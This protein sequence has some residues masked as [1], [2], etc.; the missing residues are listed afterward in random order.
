MRKNLAIV[1][2]FVS[3]SAWAQDE[4]AQLEL[5]L[6]SMIVDV[7]GLQQG[8]SISVKDISFTEFIRAIAISNDINI[9]V[10][11]EIDFRV[12]NNFVDIRVIDV[13]LFFYDNY[14][15]EISISSQIIYINPKVVL[16]SVTGIDDLKIIYS[17]STNELSVDLRMDS[18]HLVCRKISS[19]SD[20]NLVF[21]LGLGNTLITA[22][23]TEL[24]FKE[25]MEQLAFSSGLLI[26]KVDE[27]VYAVESGQ[28]KNESS[29]NKKYYSS[30]LE[31]DIT[32]VGH[33]SIS[34]SDIPLSEILDL[35]TSELEFNYFIYAPL[36]GSCSINVTA[37]SIDRLLEELFSGTDYTYSHSG[38]TYFIGPRDLESLKETSTVVL[39]HRSVEN[40]SEF[41]PEG[42]RKDVHI[43]EFHELNALILS[44]SAREIEVVEG[45]LDDIDSPV[46]LITI[47]V[48]IVDYHDNVAVEAGVQFG[49]GEEP[50]TTQGELYPALDYTMNGESINN[51]LKSFAGA[52]VVNIG[53]VTDNFYMNI[54]AL[55]EQ[56]IVSLKS[57][58]KLSTLNGHSASMKLG[59]KEYYAVEQQNI[60]GTQ[61]PQTLVTRQ[62]E[63]VE[64]NT[65]VIIKPFV[66]GN[67]DVTLEIQVNQSDFTVRIAPDAP[68][69]EVSRTFTSLIRV[70]NGEMILLGGLEELEKSES[71]TGVPVLSRIPGLKWL[72][73]TRKHSNNEAK[74]NI[75]IKPTI[76]P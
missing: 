41:I 25:A 72:F 52:G 75:F 70:K 21:E 3:F 61:N 62:Y 13:L 23:F 51:L 67:D 37:Y 30:R 15:I 53:F 8:V 65:E 32:N 59:N 9:V 2:L 49:V 43:E 29:K 40:L 58:P 36:E 66:A 22:Y 7:P 4:K 60:I 45:F 28:I 33:M 19:I 12:N 20:F 54:K 47:E 11:Q 55:E 71:S 50:T 35:L 17:D 42:I 68:P 38:G 57:T 27:K 18:L 39:K 64:A 56:G 74:L 16:P 76:I 24:P 6:E 10:D 5:Q 44:G 69:G 63:S 34:A 31:H 26:S 48:L 73:S 1:I 14:P 46:P